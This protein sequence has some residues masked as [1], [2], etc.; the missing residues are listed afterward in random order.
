MVE[1]LLNSGADVSITEGRGLQCLSIAILFHKPIATD[2]DS[3]QHKVASSIVQA[4]VK[5]GAPPNVADA[6]GTTPLHT[7]AGN[8]DA[9]TTTVLLEAGA[10][11]SA[12]DKVLTVGYV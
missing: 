7:A 10:S 2:D 1:L 12:V 8:A 9:G 5:H 11:C 3:A 6:T 4:L